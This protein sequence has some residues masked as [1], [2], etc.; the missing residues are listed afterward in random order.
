MPIPGRIGEQTA[1]L[2]RGNRDT[3][4]SLGHLCLSFDLF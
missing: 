1:R 2:A 4:P 3:L